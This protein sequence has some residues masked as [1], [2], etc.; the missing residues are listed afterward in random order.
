MLA[1]VRKLNA[2]DFV[3]DGAALVASCSVGGLRS[4][5]V[6]RS[7]MV[8]TGLRH[9]VS[10]AGWQPCGAVLFVVSSSVVFAFH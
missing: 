4:G 3:C 7:G 10:S 1:C 5:R 8:C 6:A 2:A 9:R